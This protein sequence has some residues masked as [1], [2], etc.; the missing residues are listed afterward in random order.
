MGEALRSEEILAEWS[1]AEMAMA[2]ATY[3][4]RHLSQAWKPILS[5]DMLNRSLCYL[6]DVTLTLFLDQVAKATDIS[7]S[8]CSFVYTLFEK[9]THDLQI[10]LGD[11]GSKSDSREWDRFSAVGRFMDMSIADIE[12]ALSDGVFRSVT[13][14]ELVRLVMSCFDDTPKRRALLK[15]LSSNP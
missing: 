7:S 10:L 12:V 9:A 2:A 3:H 6:I 11:S 1:D 15:V 14:P 13:G 4:L 8:A 5:T